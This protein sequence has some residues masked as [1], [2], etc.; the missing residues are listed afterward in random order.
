MRRPQ[1][2]NSPALNGYEL[3]ALAFGMSLPNRGPWA[4]HPFR[5]ITMASRAL[6]FL[7]LD[8]YEKA[9]EDAC[10]AC[11]L[12]PKYLKARKALLALQN[13]SRDRNSASWR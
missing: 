3:R 12:E 8:A 2:E 13:T 5:A 10:A 1:L 11:K 4:L 6:A 9:L 7:R